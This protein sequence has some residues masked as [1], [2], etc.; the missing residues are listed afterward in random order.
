MRSRAQTRSKRSPVFTLI[1]LLVVIAI[2]GILASMLLPALQNA[3]NKAVEIQCAS[4]QRQCGVAL[5]GYA[6][7]F[8]GWLIGGGCHSDYAAFPSLGKMMM[9]LGYAPMAG[10]FVGSPTSAPNPIPYGQVFQCPAL[11]APQASY[12]QWG[13]TYP[14]YGNDSSTFQSY[15]LRG[16]WY[17]RYYPGEQQSSTSADS[18]CRFVKIDSLYEPDSLPYMVD[19]CTTVKSG[20]TVVGRTQS[21]NWSIT[22]GSIGPYPSATPADSLNLRH[23]RR[24][25][26]WFPDGSVSTWNA[27]DTKQF[28]VPGSG[29]LGSVEFGYS[30]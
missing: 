25:N 1:E 14:Y 27:V 11:E 19:T 7:D 5:V 23:S 26:V 8:D 9:G 12:L 18:N 28:R 24:A 3:K 15:G 13:T 4:N 20:S 22:S 10:T 30:Y 17:S 29:T 2:I 21:A 16:F 6:G